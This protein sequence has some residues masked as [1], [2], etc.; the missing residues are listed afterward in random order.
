[1]PESTAFFAQNKLKRGGKIGV[2]KREEG[3]IKRCSGPQAS[4]VTLLPPARPPAALIMVA[5]LGIGIVERKI[6]E[7]ILIFSCRKCATVN[8]VNA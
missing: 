2:H 7:C 5:G 4:L 1:M 8:A 6:Y 3:T